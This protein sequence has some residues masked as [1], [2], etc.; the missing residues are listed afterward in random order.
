MVGTADSPKRTAGPP[1]KVGQTQ[2]FQIAVPK[3]LYDY[4]TYL[5]TH[6][7]LGTSEKEVAVH[8]LTRELNAMLIARYHDQR[9]PRD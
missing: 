3:P 8:L 4:L 9:I 6:S 2:S 1:P 5:A 7:I